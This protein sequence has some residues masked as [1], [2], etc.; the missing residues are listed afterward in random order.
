MI[1]EDPYLRLRGKFSIP[2][3]VT[4]L[5]R[6]FSRLKTN[7]AEWCG[8]PLANNPPTHG[9]WVSAVDGPSMRPSMRPLV[10]RCD[11]AVDQDL[12]RLQSPSLSFFSFSRVP[13]LR[14]HQVTMSLYTNTPTFSAGWMVPVV[15]VGHMPVIHHRE[16]SIHVRPSLH[17]R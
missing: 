2:R 8:V 4:H 9:V 17:Y 15:H 3:L 11:G 1:T 7:L 10:P 5:C 13:L 14:A 16:P 12:Q 6:H